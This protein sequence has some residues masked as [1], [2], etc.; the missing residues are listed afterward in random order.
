MAQIESGTF[1]TFERDERA[2]WWRVTN[3]KHGD[4]LGYI[5]RY[6][7]WRCWVFEPMGGTVFSAGCLDEIS[8]CCERRMME[9]RHVRT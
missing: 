8:A 7:P 2:L 6:A 4:A 5:K 1:I 9:D 3:K